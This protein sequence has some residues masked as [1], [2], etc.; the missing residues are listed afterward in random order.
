MKKSYLSADAYLL[1]S[2]RLARMIMDSG[3]I[4]DLII[5]LWRGGAP[6]GICIHEFFVYHHIPVTHRVLQCKSYCGIGKSSGTVE[7]SNLD[8]VCS[9]LNSGMKVLVVDD[10]FDSGRTVEAVREKL[11]PLCGEL[12][13]AT[14]YWKPAANR[15]NGTPD[16][17]LRKTDEWLVFPHEMD[18]LSAEEMQEKNR[19][20]AAILDGSRLSSANSPSMRQRGGNND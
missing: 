5:P 9:V 20:L 10:V 8:S 18:G 2:F 12:R 1:D 6:V 15:T 14:V 7:F 3:W 17:Y 13:V 11:T 4:P 16:Y 19:E